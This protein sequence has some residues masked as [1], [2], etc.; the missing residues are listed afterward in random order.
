MRA[1]AISLVVLL[2]ACSLFQIPAPRHSEPITPCNRDRGP[3]KVDLIA[4]TLTV[5]AG[6]AVIL[7]IEP[8][9]EDEARDV[10][11]TIIG[12]SGVVAGAGM[13]ASAKIGSNRANGR[14][15]STKTPVG[16]PDDSQR[17]R[18]AQLVIA[19]VENVPLVDRC[20]SIRMPL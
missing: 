15:L 10:A 6:L 16:E 14:E 11:G 8:R 18:E 19:E 5:V 13:L 2:S 3:V 4:G 7:F 17:V 1:L 12:A 20:L 9:K